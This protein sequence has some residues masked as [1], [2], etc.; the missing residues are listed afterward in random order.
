MGCVL[1]VVQHECIMPAGRLSHTGPRAGI[2]GTLGLIDS[3]NS[4][5]LRCVSQAL[6]TTA[7]PTHLG[8]RQRL[9]GVLVEPLVGLTS[10]SL[11]LLNHAGLQES[12]TRHCNSQ[13]GFMVCVQA[14]LTLWLLGWQAEQ[15]QHNSSRV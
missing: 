2:A 13:H 7:A 1:L 8:G 11:D 6:S 9:L 4:S 10:R 3:I 15:N 12:V 14:F 5:S